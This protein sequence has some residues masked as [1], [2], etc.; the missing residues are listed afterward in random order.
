MKKT[1]KIFKLLLL[2]IFTLTTFLLATKN[3]RAEEETIEIG[4]APQLKNSYIGGIAFAY[5][6]TT[7][8]EYLYCLDISKKTAA[9]VTA[10]RVSNTPLDNGIIYILEN[11][12]PYKNIT[13]D[14]EKDYYITQTALWWYLDETTG[15]MNLGERFKETG[16]DY[17]DLRK[18]VKSLMQQGLKHRYDT[19]VSIETKLELSTNDTNMKLN[20]DYFESSDIKAKVITNMSSYLVSLSNIP[21]NTI[22]S[23]NGID[24]NYDAPFTVSKDASFRIKIPTSAITDLSS[25]ISVTAK[26]NDAYETSTAYEYEPVNGTMQ[27]VTR[28]EKIAS[29]AH[30]E[31]T[32]TIST[33]KVSITKIDTNTK[34]SLA[35]AK[36]VLLD[37]TGKEITSWTSTT[38]AHIIRNL[39]NGTYTLK[40]IAPPVGYLLNTEETSFT[41]SDTKKEINITFENAPK[42]VV[43]NI[44]KVDQATNA[45]LAGATI[46]VK[47]SL[48]NIIKRFTTT[49]SSYTLTDLADGV[50][51]V[52][53][54]SAPS[55]YIRN[56]EIVTF[57]V[58]DEHLS[59]QIIIQNAKE[60][61]VP[62]TLS[63]S[64]LSIVT[65]IL[66]ITIFGAGFE[67]IYKNKKHAKK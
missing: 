10:R 13:G 37:S 61:I 24:K 22:V 6:M 21:E 51:T 53:E 15:S 63:A 60:V 33:S 26:E 55:G 47:D 18:H 27:N 16:T 40:E 12:Y 58:D 2:I 14:K 41:I 44:T 57:K 23:I 5:K 34:Q 64:T 3:V 56:T 35:G 66:G 31:L 4:D 30:S 39:S 46:V 28:L 8:G 20:G 29:E 43:V 7:S 32:L 67:Y 49:T 9:N 42:K 54:E 59:H 11:G 45:P 1:S 62:D 65:F 19:R 38:N 50:Y 52:E 25:N 36:F 48:G 17:Y